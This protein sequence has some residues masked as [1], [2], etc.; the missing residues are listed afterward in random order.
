ML[1][2]VDDYLLITKD[3]AK[4]L[5]FLRTMTAGSSLILCFVT[6]LLA[7]DFTGH[8]EYGCFISTEKT[9]TNFYAD[10]DTQVLDHSA[11]GTVACFRTQK[12]CSFYHLTS[13]FPWCGLLIDPKNLDVSV[14]YSRYANQS[15]F[16]PFGII[17]NLKVR[18][19]PDIA[20]AV[21]V[22]KSRQPGVK[23]EYTI[24]Q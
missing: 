18:E 6:S 7:K 24:I 21:S 1:R 5:H 19:V 17:Q 15:K 2:W 9:L 14:D 4:A 3:K 20:N 10:F 13:G 11:A 23:L 16:I 22:T 12:T 8:P